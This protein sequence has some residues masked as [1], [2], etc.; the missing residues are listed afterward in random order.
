MRNRHGN[1]KVKGMTM[2]KRAG[3]KDGKTEGEK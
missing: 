2:R 3:R 1:K